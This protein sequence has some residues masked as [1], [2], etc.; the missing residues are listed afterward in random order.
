[1]RELYD[2][3]KAQRHEDER[4]QMKGEVQMFGEVATPIEQREDPGKD[5]Q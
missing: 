3:R 1:M 4:V 2:R 5:R